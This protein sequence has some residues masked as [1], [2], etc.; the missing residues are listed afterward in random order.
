[1]SP[2][3]KQDPHGETTKTTRERIYAAHLLLLWKLK[4]FAESQN[5]PFPQVVLSL[6]ARMS[7]STEVGMSLNRQL[8][9][10]KKPILILYTKETLK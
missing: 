9:L 7:Y 1:M 3:H 4:H 2:G 8:S 6:D 10:G 5:L